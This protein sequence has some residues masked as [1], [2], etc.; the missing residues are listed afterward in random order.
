MRHQ[1]SITYNGRKEA[2]NTEL[3]IQDTRTKE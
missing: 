3:D 1:E 2:K